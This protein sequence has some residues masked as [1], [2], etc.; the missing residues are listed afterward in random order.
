MKRG[1]TLIELLAVI[2]ILAIIALIATP[3]ILN[4]IDETKDNASLR[5]AEFYL[6][7]VEQSILMA[8]LNNRRITDGKYNI[9]NTGNI[10][11]EKVDNECKEELVIE[12]K[13]EKPNK[14]I[15]SIQNGKI[16]S[17]DITLG[18]NRVVLN[19]NK[20]VIHFPCTLIS[21]KENE[22]GSK[23]ECEVKPG[24]KYNFYVLSKEEDKINLIMERNICQDG[25]VATEENTCL[26]AW[27][28]NTDYVCD[29]NTQGTACAQHYKGPV[30]AMTYLY[31]ATKDWTNI[32]NMIM[33][34]ED[35]NINSIT[36]KPGTGQV[37]YGSIK[38]ENNITTITKKYG[39]KTATYKN[40]KSRLPKYSEINE[41]GC[42][43]K[44]GSC[45]LW[46]VDYLHDNTTS[47]R[48]YNSANGKC[49]ISIYAL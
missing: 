28:T 29:P 12:V 26:V 34:Y 31:N 6:D 9:L 44:E 47:N 46:L 33:D 15:I 8:T 22:I 10:C 30:T 2:V 32:P 18:D 36:G 19:D 5:S 43:T 1:F 45:P 38:T 42:T 21:G 40:L 49:P 35:E 13:G 16:E 17:I 14:G 48:Y 7:A 11:I 37:S 25:S 23:Y 24:T 27:I 4:I 41:N 20:D 3:I 39:T